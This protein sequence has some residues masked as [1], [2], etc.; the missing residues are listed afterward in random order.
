MHCSVGGDPYEFVPNSAFVRRSRAKCLASMMNIRG[1]SKPSRVSSQIE[2]IPRVPSQET[3]RA[4]SQT[5]K[6]S[7]AQ[8]SRTPSQAERI[9]SQ[10]R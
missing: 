2:S 1:S 10:D 3:K 4:W 5:E 7:G 9:P 6:R 8:P